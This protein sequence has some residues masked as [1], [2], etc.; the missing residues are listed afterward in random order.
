MLDLDRLVRHFVEE[1]SVVRYDKNASSVI[2]DEAFKP[3]YGGDVEVVRRLVEKQDIR[4]AEQELCKRKLRAL[5]ARKLFHRH[6][7]VALAKAETDKRRL[8]AAD[9]CKTAVAF[10]FFAQRHFLKKKFLRVVAVFHLGHDLGKALLG[11]NKL[12]KYA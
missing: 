2:L 7:K 8:C 9:V 4:P 3:V 11:E 5:T 10:K 1:V 12:F 6:I